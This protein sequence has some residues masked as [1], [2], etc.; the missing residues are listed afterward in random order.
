MKAPLQE[1]KDRFG[2]K[3]KLADELVKLLE[4]DED[5]SKE[6]FK[7]RLASVSNAKLLHLHAVEEEVK[8]QGGKASLVDAILAAS[9]RSKDKDYQQKLL[10]FANTRLMDE[11][12][13]AQRAAKRGLGHG[14]RKP[15]LDAA[16]RKR[17]RAKLHARRKARAQ[18]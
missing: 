7:A 9:N 8:E 17:R 2:S 16:R 4:K 14:K 15:V 1:V 18:V 10:T 6:E 5:E 3:E 11:L 13:S 12:R